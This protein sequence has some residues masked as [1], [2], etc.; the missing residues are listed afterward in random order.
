MAFLV[1]SGSLELHTGERDFPI[2][3]GEEAGS[4]EIL[5]GLRMPG[6]VRCLTFGHLLE[7]KADDLRRIA[8]GNPIIRANLD[9]LR[10]R[11]M[12]D[13]GASALDAAAIT[14]DVVP[15]SAA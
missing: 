15:P 13:R 4:T 7:I 6:T 14:G 2:G 10:S 11:R 5:G 8:A 3:P 9:R 12:G 1:S